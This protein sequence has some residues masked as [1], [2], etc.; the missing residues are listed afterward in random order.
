MIYFDPVKKLLIF[1]FCLPAVAFCQIGGQHVYDFLNLVPSARVAAIGGAN[2]SVYDYDPG[3]AYYNPALVS[4]TMHDQMTL[5]WV[6]YLAGVN[7]GYAGYARTFEGIG[8]FHASIQYVGYGKMQQT[9]ALGNV[10]GEFGANEMVLTVGGARQY[11]NFRF[12][13]NLKFIH[14]NIG[15]AGSQGLALDLGGLYVSDDGLFTGGLV[16]R[17]IG[18]QLTRYNPTGDREP[19]PFEVQLGISKKLK[20]MPLRFSVT[21][22]NLEHPQLIY[23]DP[24]AEP[25]F[26]LSGNEIEPKKQIGDKIFRHFVFGAEFLISK[27]VNLRAGYNH[28]R[29][30]ELRSEGRAGLSGVSLGAGIKVSKFNI[31][32]AFTKFHAVGGMH[33]FGIGT[34]IG[35]FKKPAASPQ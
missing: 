32:Y 28:M 3:F 12:G 11:Y 17:N 18:F 1:L 6:N 2:V 7:Y 31:D 10:T 14:S 25:E 29:R 8:D 22:T 13:T 19:L 24:D 20:H 16:M 30:A 34:N 27:H 33:H 5:N 26:D 9:D 21:A 15:G 23:E 4:D 35:S